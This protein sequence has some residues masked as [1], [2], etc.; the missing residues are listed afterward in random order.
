MA[1]ET[2]LLIDDDVGLLQLHRLALKGK[3]DYAVLTSATGQTALD[4]L[5]V[6][7]PDIVILDLMMPDMSGTE[8]CR[9]IRAQTRLR[10]TPIAV[11]TGL[12]DTTAHAAV[13]EAGATAIW[14]KPLTPSELIARIKQLLNPSH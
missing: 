5:E 12:S 7:T 10:S 4:Q 11:L 3:T 1:N 14:I 13:R 8:I 6:V 2:V 9:R